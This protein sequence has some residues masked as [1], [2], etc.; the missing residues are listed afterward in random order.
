M[1]NKLKE[2]VHELD[3]SLGGILVNME[4]IEAIKT[5]LGYVRGDVDDTDQKDLTSM[6]LRFRD[7]THKIVLLDD[8]IRFVS[9][10]LN[11]NF[12]VASEIKGQLFHEIVEG[13]SHD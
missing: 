5:E 2:L 4:S 10:D 6:A 8:L 3:S 9:K 1:G 12:E 13:G 11:S 7:I